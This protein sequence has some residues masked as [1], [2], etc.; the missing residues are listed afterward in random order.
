M[1]RR[2]SMNTESVRSLELGLQDEQIKEFDR[3]LAAEN[4][5]IEFNLWHEMQ[6]LFQIAA[7]AMVVQVSV[8]FIFP[9]T[10]SAVG[11]SLGTEALA[12]F[13]LGSLVGNLT[14]VSIMTGVLKA[15]DVLMPRAWGAQKYEEMGIL[16]VR[17]IIICSFFL[18]IPIIPLCTSM[19]KIFVSIGQDGHAS[20]L[21][22]QWIR[23]F[24]IGVPSSLLFRVAQSFLNSQNQVYPMVFASVIA[25]YV[26]HPFFL[27]MLIPTMGENGSALAISLTQWVMV[28]LL[29]LYL[30]FRPVEKPET[31]PKFSRAVLSEA[32]SPQPMLDFISLSLGGVLA[33]SEW[34]LWE[35]V[36]FIVGT[37][38][39]VP[40]VVH[41]IAYN[42]VPL[43]FMPTLGMNIGLTVRIGHIIA[44]DIAKAKLLAAWCMFFTVMFGAILSATLYIFQVEIAMI[45]TDDMEVVAGCKEIWAKLC[46]HVFIL[47][48]FGINSAILQVLGLQWRMAVIIFCFLWFV[49]LPAILYFA[50][51]RGG[52][53]DVVWTI[54]PVFYTAMQV[55]LALSY[56][57]ADWECIGKEIHARAHGELSPKGP[58]KGDES[59]R[60]LPS[61]ANVTAVDTEA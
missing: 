51:Y 43:L 30:R 41:S 20:F 6:L 14:V 34:W 36:C 13:S 58:I 25:S 57:T 39:V 7:P 10:A 4:D 45:F 49:T 33:L 18:A 61:K 17:G 31:W 2:P 44:Y 9:Q 8:L 29:F 24:L 48:A 21:A 52:G 27:R 50:V 11:L 46:F 54:L 53:L 26:V 5:D 16:A 28:G 59:M 32:L 12:G 42:L 60:L 3:K 55:P 1:M 47:H 40:L 35:T 22:A 56:V 19:E 15:A 38:G 23:V 37:F